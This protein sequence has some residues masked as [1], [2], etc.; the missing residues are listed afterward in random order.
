MFVAR[1]FPV[2]ILK[3][4]NELA[5]CVLVMAEH[6][7]SQRECVQRTDAELEVFDAISRSLHPGPG[8]PLERVPRVA[9]A[10]DRRDERTDLVLRQERGELRKRRHDLLDVPESHSRT[11][12]L[13]ERVRRDVPGQS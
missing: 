6:R 2:R 9:D 1:P 3:K 7:Q 13:V 11:K 4:N 5:Q 12:K 8:E 10:T